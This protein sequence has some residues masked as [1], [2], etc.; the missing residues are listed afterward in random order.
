MY[1]PDPVLNYDDSDSD[2]DSEEEREKE[3]QRKLL[4]MLDQY[5]YIPNKGNETQS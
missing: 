1:E 2:I 3:R 4:L 5:R